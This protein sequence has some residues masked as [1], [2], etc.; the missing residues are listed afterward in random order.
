MFPGS[1]LNQPGF[2]QYIVDADMH[3][4]W[5]H[6]RCPHR[7]PRPKDYRAAITTAQNTERL[8]RSAFVAIEVLASRHP[9]AFISLVFLLKDLPLELKVQLYLPSPAEH[10]EDL[11]PRFAL[12]MHHRD[13]V[14]SDHRYITGLPD[15]PL[16]GLFL[17]EQKCLPMPP[18]L[19]G[20]DQ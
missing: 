9:E 17:A 19:S 1:E 20:D 3:A 8:D 2:V 10:C 13:T 12:R 6:T 14:F 16:H 4:Q 11:H 7:L 5:L 18:H 15:G